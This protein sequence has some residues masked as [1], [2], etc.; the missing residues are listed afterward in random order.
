MELVVIST[1][2][3]TGE[4]NSGLK[5][6]NALATRLHINKVSLKD[7]YKHIM[8]HY[9]FVFANCQSKRRRV[10]TGIVI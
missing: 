1:E 4:S 7:L 10:L 8:S 6:P 9:Y 3:L 5:D 2:S